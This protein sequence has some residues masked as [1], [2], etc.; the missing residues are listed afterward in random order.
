FFNEYHTHHSRQE[1]AFEQRQELYQLYHWLNHY[2]LFGG[3]YR[4]TSIS[5]MKKLRNLV[6]E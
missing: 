4:E 6:D 1:P 5:I 2:Y 3:G